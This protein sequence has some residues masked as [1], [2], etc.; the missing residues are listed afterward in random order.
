MNI[1]IKATN[2]EISEQLSTY[3]TDKLES[4]KHFLGSPGEEVSAKVELGRETKHHRQ[5]DLFRA[6][7]NLHLPGKNLRAV[8]RGEDLFV[9]MD[10]MRDEIVREITSYRSKQKTLLRRGG[11]ALKNFL[12]RW[13]G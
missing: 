2:V 6:E 5:G 12:H 10:Q 7:I 4:V 3:L 13:R 11:R 9:A 1:N 8:G